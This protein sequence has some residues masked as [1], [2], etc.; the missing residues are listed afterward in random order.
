M[1][2]G[3]VFYDVHRSVPAKLAVYSAAIRDG[4]GHVLHR[5]L[6]IVQEEIEG[7]LTVRQ[8]TLLLDL[9]PAPKATPVPVE[10]GTDRNSIEHFLVREALEPFLAE[11]SAQRAKE[12]QTV[13]RHL[14]ISLNEL[15][16]RQNLKLADL[17]EMQ[18][19]GDTSPLLAANTKQVED[20]L[21]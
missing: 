10:S 8:P 1:E 12:I 11:V 14:E 4:L 6:F 7:T 5:R 13:T 15:I 17:I 19:N 9:V 18:Q 3:A 2:K 21:T 16:H 20:R